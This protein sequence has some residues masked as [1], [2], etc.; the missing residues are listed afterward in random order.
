[1]EAR[2]LRWAALVVP[3]LTVGVLVGALLLRLPPGWGG[4]LLGAL[5]RPEGSMIALLVLAGALGLVGALA[6]LAHAAGGVSPA[7]HLALFP[8]APPAIGAWQGSADDEGQVSSRPPPRSG[9]TARRRG[10]GPGGT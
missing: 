9:S 3:A 10:R 7:W 4:V 2:V 1:M 5:A 8:G 6:R